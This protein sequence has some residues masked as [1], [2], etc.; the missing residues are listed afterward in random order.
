MFITERG[1]RTTRRLIWSRIGSQG[2][3]WNYSEIP[4]QTI[5]PNYN[6]IIFRSIRGY[7]WE[8]DIAIDNVNVEI[9]ACGGTSFV[10]WDQSIADFYGIQPPEIKTTQLPTVITTVPTLSCDTIE[11]DKIENACCGGNLKSRH[12]WV[13]L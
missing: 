8:S 4:I 1:F 7:S 5:Y 6:Q 13:M 11:F 9:G 12:P 10:L 3:G 2:D